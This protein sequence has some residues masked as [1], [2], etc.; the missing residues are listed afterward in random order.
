MKDSVVDIYKLKIKMLEPYPKNIR[1]EM[2]LHTKYSKL[3][4]NGFN[5]EEFDVDIN[6]I[7]LKREDED[8]KRLKTKLIRAGREI[9]NDKRPED[10]IFT[11][12]VY[13]YITR[14]HL[15]NLLRS[16]HRRPVKLRDS[17]YLILSMWIHCVLTMDADRFT[18][19]FLEKKYNLFWKE[20]ERFVLKSKVKER[21]QKIEKLLAKFVGNS[22]QDLA[23]QFENEPDLFL[24]KNFPTQISFA[25]HAYEKYYLTG[26]VKTDK[27]AIDRA[28]KE[29]TVKRKD[30]DMEKV[31]NVLR[32]SFN[33]GTIKV[34]GGKKVV[35]NKEEK[36][37]FLRAGSPSD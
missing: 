21:D 30:P 10:K 6:S 11:A 8:S 15:S 7:I 12:K 24:P 32:V 33:K 35:Y 34:D 37:W 4:S 1:D 20:C 18:S 2:K 9:I 14:E 13:I 23:K 27:E 28:A 5:F 29:C 19:I 17:R 16:Y 3:F 25:I 31:L 22:E 26:E 36:K